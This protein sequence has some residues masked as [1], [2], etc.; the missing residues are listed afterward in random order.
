MTKIVLGIH[1]LGNKPPRQTLGL[2]W[3]AAIRE[4]LRNRAY[5]HPL[6]KFELIYW[7][8]ILHPQPHD[9]QEED[10]ENILFLCEPYVPADDFAHREIDYHRKRWL[11]YIEEKMDK[12]LLKADMSINFQS[13]TEA[14]LSRYFQDLEIYFHDE[15]NDSFS[16]A[17]NRARELIRQRVAKVLQRHRTKEILLIAHSMGSIIAYDVLTQM[18]PEVKIDTFITIGSPLGLPVVMS[19]VFAEQQDQM[20]FLKKPVCPE[21]IK[22]QWYN[23]SDLEDLVAINYNLADDYQPNSRGVRAQDM[24]VHN[25]YH[26]N[27]ER[28]PHKSY[29]YLRTPECA[30]AIHFFHLGHRNRMVRW[31]KKRFA[32][33][34]ARYYRR[35]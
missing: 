32:R 27:G 8:D 14:V 18:M 2:W 3:R 25:N 30:R 31:L 35:I 4:G 26:I 19:K 5:V 28:N 24:I 34:M 29:G 10:E 13:L 9:P 33:V 11:D 1:G 17:A 16:R 15:G 21:N 23:L 22:K 6:L 7:A 12:L 20:E